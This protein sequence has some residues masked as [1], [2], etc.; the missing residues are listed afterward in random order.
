MHRLGS[1]LY[2]NGSPKTPHL[3]QCWSLLFVVSCVLRALVYVQS[4]GRIVYLFIMHNQRTSL[5]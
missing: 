1:L 5:L 3:T 4:L 2:G